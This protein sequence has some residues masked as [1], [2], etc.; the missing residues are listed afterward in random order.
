MVRAGDQ[1]GLVTVTKRRQQR[2][3][4][5]NARELKVVHDWTEIFEKFWTQHI[6]RIKQCVGSRKAALS[7][8]RSILAMYHQGKAASSCMDEIDKAIRSCDRGMNQ[9]HGAVK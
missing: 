2:L 7:Q 5:L 3:Y 4:Q 6:D 9:H 8:V 1:L